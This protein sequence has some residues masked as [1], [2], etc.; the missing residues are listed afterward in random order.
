MLCVLLG[1]S[2]LFDKSGADPFKAVWVLC[3]ELGWE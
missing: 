2:E 3:S 1:D